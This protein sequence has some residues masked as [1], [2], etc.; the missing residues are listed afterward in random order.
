MIRTAVILAARRERDSEIPYPLRTFETGEGISNLFERT[1]SIFKNLN[2]K[3]IYVVVGYKKELFEKYQYNEVLLIEN[4]DYAFTSSMGSLA[5]CEPYIKED[6]L[7]VESDT[8]FEKKVLE[9]LSSTTHDNSIT[10]TEESGN[11]DEA[12]VQ[13]KNGFVEKVSKDRHQIL[14]VDGEMIG[15]TK[16]SLLVF[17]HM[18]QLYK[19]ASNRRVN[20]EYLFIDSTREIDRPYIRFKNLIWG[21]VDNEKDFVKLKNEIYPRL[22]RKENPY[23][24]ENL[25]SHLRTI[26]LNTQIDNTWNIEQIGGMS[27]KNFKVISPNRVE[28]VLRVPGIGAEG[29]VGRSSEDCNGKLACSMGLN[30]EIVYFNDKTGI[31]LSTFIHNAETLNQGTI[32]R[33]DNMKQIAKILKSLHNSKVRFTNEFNIF[34]EI[35]KYEKL[36]S[37]AGGKMYEGYESIRERVINLENFLNELGIDIC[38][39]HSDLVPENFIK[40]ENGRIWLIDWEYSGMNDPMADLAA[41]FLESSFSEDN[42][43]Y[44]LDEYFNGDVPKNTRLKI[45]AYQILW[46]YLW[47]LWTVIKETQGD[48]FGDYGPKRYHRAIKLLSKIGK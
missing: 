15:L 38:P 20:Y 41:L 18:C 39:C 46:D 42:I 27:N 31:K 25:Y 47:T 23:D 6:F 35:E 24:I 34:H 32:Q 21:E 43:D 2:F 12:F 9:Q 33:M 11:G 1:L 30:P 26:F 10:I 29:M 3:H 4:K 5:V 14:H 45:T 28:Y 19:T 7:L 40:D 8:F 17:R 16:I 48:N 44:V 13:T 37:T 36:L 22:R